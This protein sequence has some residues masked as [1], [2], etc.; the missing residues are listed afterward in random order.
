MWLSRAIGPRWTGFRLR[1]FPTSCRRG[2]VAEPAQTATRIASRDRREYAGHGPIPADA[3]DRS[4]SGATAG[5]R[6][7]CSTGTAGAVSTYSRFRSSSPPIRADQL[8]MLRGCEPA[9]P[10]APAERSRWPTT[11]PTRDGRPASTGSTYPP[12]SPGAAGPQAR[13]PLAAWCFFLPEVNPPSMSP[14]LACRTRFSDGYMPP[15]RLSSTATVYSPPFGEVARPRSRCRAMGLHRF[16]RY[17][18]VGRVGLCR[19]RGGAGRE[20]TGLAGLGS[21]EAGGCPWSISA[22]RPE[23]RARVRAW[24]MEVRVTVLSRRSPCNRTD[25]HMAGSPWD[26][27]RCGETR[28]GGPACDGRVS[29]HAEREG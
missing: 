21:P 2:G 9:Y 5:I 19:R 4:G 8:A 10:V 1:A 11:R 27:D 6:G 20:V 18:D 12:S 13:R 26:F 14:V 7:D 22:W 28:R 25:D 23:M 29:I 15:S 17:V 3:F 16:A 24:P